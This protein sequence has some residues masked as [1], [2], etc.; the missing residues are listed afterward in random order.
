MPCII[1]GCTNPAPHRFGVRLRKPPKRHGIW[2]PETHAFICDDHAVMG[3]KITVTLEPASTGTIE[4]TV[5]G[6]LPSG[7]SRSTLKRTTPIKKKP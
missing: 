3:M 6:V 5:T 1:P 4:T 7:A 2:T